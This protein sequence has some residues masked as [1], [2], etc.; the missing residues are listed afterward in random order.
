MQVMYDGERD[1]TAAGDRWLT[2]PDAAAY[3]GLSRSIIQRWVVAG[4]LTAYRPAG[5]RRRLVRRSEL[6]AL[7]RAGAGA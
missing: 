1:A 2:I 3:A 7:I 6:D 4:R 5:L